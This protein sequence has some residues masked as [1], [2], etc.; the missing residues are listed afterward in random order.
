MV[1]QLCGAFNSFTHYLFKNMSAYPLSLTKVEW[2]VSSGNCRLLNQHDFSTMWSDVHSEEVRGRCKGVLTRLK[3]WEV[4]WEE[5]AFPA[6][7]EHE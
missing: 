7:A 3:F 1:K 6:D 4:P 5:V 2:S